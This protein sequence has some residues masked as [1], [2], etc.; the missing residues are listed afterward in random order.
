[1]HLLQNFNKRLS[2][3]DIFLLQ[4][5]TTFFDWKVVRYIKLEPLTNFDTI[6]RGLFYFVRDH[7]NFV[8]GFGFL[9]APQHV[10]S[11]PWPSFR[12]LEVDFVPLLK[13]L[14]Y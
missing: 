2:L 14:F 13:L 9:F 8:R 5:K 7:R 11:Y 4:N 12:T 3:I 1:M 6:V 10:C